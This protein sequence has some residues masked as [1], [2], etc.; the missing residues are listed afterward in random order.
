MPP[1]ASIAFCN[2]DCTFSSVQSPFLSPSRCRQCPWGTSMLLTCSNKCLRFRLTLLS[3]FLC[4]R[5]RNHSHYFAALM[6]R[7][8][9]QLPRRQK[10][11]AR[12]SSNA[13]FFSLKLGII[14]MPRDSEN[15]H[16]FGWWTS[17]DA[18]YNKIYFTIFPITSAK[19]CFKI[20]KT[21]CEN[22][23]KL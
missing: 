8:H 17:Q 13:H 19:M 22:K 18:D 11:S 5:L 23:T 16:K 6:S 15:I 4:M 12:Y 14:A 20:L 1:H 7:S 3:L 21:R 2:S 10:L 9:V